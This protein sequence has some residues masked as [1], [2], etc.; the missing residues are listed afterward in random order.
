MPNEQERESNVLQLNARERK[1]IDKGFR[2]PNEI[3]EHVRHW[4]GERTDAALDQLITIL[5]GRRGH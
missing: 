5:K 4:L 3:P 1:P 2:E